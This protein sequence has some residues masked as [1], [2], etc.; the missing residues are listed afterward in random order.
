MYR[1]EAGAGGSAAR[2]MVPAGWL[3]DK[4]KIIDRLEKDVV[5]LEAELESEGLKKV[6]RDEKATEIKEETEG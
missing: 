1:D 3:E 2:G 6:G 5:R 4:Q